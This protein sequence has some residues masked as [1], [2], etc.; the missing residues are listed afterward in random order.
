MGDSSKFSMSTCMLLLE[1]NTPQNYCTQINLKTKGW[2]LVCDIAV[3][4]IQIL[5]LLDTALGQMDEE[6][7]IPV[8]LWITGNMCIPAH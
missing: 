8:H 2:S 6:A 7:C 1:M 4:N 5:T 3:N